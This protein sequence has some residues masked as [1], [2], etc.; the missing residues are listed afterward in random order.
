[1]SNPDHTCPMTHAEIVDAYFL[2]HR[3]RLLDI[4]AFMDRCD[5]AQPGG[6]ED[7]FRMSALREAL[8]ILLD[9]QTDRARRVLELMSDQSSEPVDHAPMKGALGTPQPE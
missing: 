8:A 5:R 9:G 2:E 1:M 7:D 6:E 3:A 4:A